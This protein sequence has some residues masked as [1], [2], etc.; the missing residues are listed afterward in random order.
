MSE[1]RSSG[2]E[3]AARGRTLADWSQYLAQHFSTL[4]QSRAQIGTPIFVLEHGLNNDEL[5]E[6]SEKLLQ[7]IRLRHP[8]DQNWLPWI[9]Y[10][11]ERGYSYEGDEY[12]H[13]FEEKTVGWDSADRYRVTQWFS[14]FCDEYNG[15]I[16]SGPWA[17]HFSII[18]GP[19]THAILPR[20][21]QLQFARA[22]YNLRFRL[23]TVAE[24]GAT[25]VGQWFAANVEHPTTRFSQFLQQEELTG[26][27]ILALLGG[28]P[29]E[30][31]ERIY[32]STLQRIVSDLDQV[33]SART[34]LSETRRVV[35]SRERA[36]KQLNPTSHP[37]RTP[38]Q[39]SLREAL[40]IRPQ[41]V[42]RYAGDDAWDAILRVPSF[43]ALAALDGEVQ[44][45]LRRTRCKLN[46]VDGLKPA[47][48]VLSGPRHALLKEWPNS[49]LP[50]VDFESG[51]TSLDYLLQSKCSF[52]RTEPLLFRLSK[53]G[54][55]RQVSGTSVRSGSEYVVVSSSEVPDGELISDARLSCTGVNAFKITVPDLVSD[56]SR[57][58]LE[59]LGLTVARTVQIWPA[60]LPSRSWCESGRSEWSTTETPCFGVT[61][62]FNVNR[63]LVKLDDGEESSI[64]PEGDRKATFLMLPA[65]SSGEYVL[66]ITAHDDQANDSVTGEIA[67]NVYE[68]VHWSPGTLQSQALLIS[69][70]PVDADLDALWRNELEVSVVGPQS[71][72]ASFSVALQNAAGAEIFSEAV[73]KSVSLP[74]ASDT[75]TSMFE[76]FLNRE[77]FCWRYL[78][79][80]TG[81]LRVQADELGTF[82]AHFQHDVS[83]VRF[84]LRR[85]KDGIILRLVDETGI[86]DQLPNARVYRMEQPAEAVELA[87]NDLRR[88]LVVDPPGGLFTVEHGNYRDSILVS[89]GLAG[90]GLQGLG[91][92][93][94]VELSDAALALTFSNVSC[95][96]N[97]R[98]VG[99]L[100]GVRRRQITRELLRYFYASICGSNWERREDA[101]LRDVKSSRV[102]DQLERAVCK[103]LSF[104]IILSRNF[105]KIAADPKSSGGW[106][107]EL[108]RSFGLA[109]SETDCEFAL[110]LASSPQLIADKYRN[111]IDAR[112]DWLQNN[113]AIF[114]GARLV[115]LLSANAEVKDGVKF[116][117]AWKW[118]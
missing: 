50:L 118:K 97:A 110:M 16:P 59:A 39:S 22:L 28:E 34:W 2:Q 17:R 81:S 62:N 88:G 36:T 52:Q 8:F 101:F 45:F 11:T 14:K 1:V 112:L 70:E 15:F 113:P 41:I 60:G 71:H 40:D 10:A 107:S 23:P 5:V 31:E 32:P 78:E 108:A 42:L 83:P 77:D 29:V 4:A 72:T 102:K 55:A 100:A 89:S 99:M 64:V 96:L 65:L 58:Q 116:L 63:Y 47:G 7:G 114:R 80:A 84:S 44:S 24:S 20:Y 105:A 109:S 35:S 26:R 117:P 90:S 73:G 38:S 87:V 48:W 91:I 57:L 98:S 106:Y 94:T 54:N 51:L 49:K 69:V 93:P 19:I 25:E 13:S 67:V 92:T 66:S 86:D 46:G 68:P 37:R 74:V 75:W 104:A 111:E 3:E 12:W 82:Y 6:I 21:L 18:A 103:T 43:H 79:A 56:E 95:W 76:R 53:D 27:I 61:S 30:G 9:V 115:S 33:Q 85:H